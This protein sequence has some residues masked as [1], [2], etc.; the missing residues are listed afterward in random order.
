MFNI[1]NIKVSPVNRVLEIVK[2][3]QANAVLTLLST[4]EMDS[5][6]ESSNIYDYSFEEGNPLKDV[7]NYVKP[8]DWKIVSFEDYDGGD[9]IDI[10]TEAKVKEAIQFGIKKLDEGK[11][12]LV[13]CQMG[14]SRSPAIAYLIMCHYMDPQDAINELHKIRKGSKPNKY[15]I[16]IGDRVMGLNGK[17]IMANKNRTEVQKELNSSFLKTMPSFQTSV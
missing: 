17:A 1:N 10:P 5:F 6:N 3:G 11:K 16:E 14:M 4:V 7:H 12:L 2:T 8:E 13:H 15:I 9:V